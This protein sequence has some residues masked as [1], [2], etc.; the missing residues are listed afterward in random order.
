MA[1][2]LKPAEHDA[3]P[4][5][6]WTV[7]KINDRLWHLDSS[8]GGTFQ[9]FT[10][11]KAAEAAKTAGWLVNLYDKEGRWFRG[12]PVAGWKPYR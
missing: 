1:L 6:A 5:T 8:Q 9:N 12:E 10:T 2:H 3:D 7:V 4:P 11:K